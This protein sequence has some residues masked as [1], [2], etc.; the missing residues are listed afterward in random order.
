MFTQTKHLYLKFS[1]TGLLLIGVSTI[2]AAFLPK[3][4]SKTVDNGVLRESRTPTVTGQQTCKPG[5][6]AFNCTYTATDGV[7]STT[8]YD[9][10]NGTSIIAGRTAA[11]DTVNGTHTSLF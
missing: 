3:R 7:L 9:G 4:T 1:I 11:T 5:S 8:T 10:R 6:G 2:V